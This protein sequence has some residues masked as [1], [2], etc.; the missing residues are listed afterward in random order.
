VA[1]VAPKSVF[2]VG[3]A[4]SVGT[5]S[6][7]GMPVLDRL[8]RAGA[9]VWPFQA[10]GWP[11]VVEIYPR[12]LTGAVVKSNAAARE[13]FLQRTCPLLDAQHA[14]AATASEDAFDAA[15]SALVMAGTRSDLMALPPEP[16][17]RVRVEGR[18]WHPAWRQDRA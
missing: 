2:Q 17:A 6:L 3:G 8:F 4:G 11:L 5:G 16:D 18:I 7:R 14:Q 12:L 10:G 9:C 13:A 1:G 15:V